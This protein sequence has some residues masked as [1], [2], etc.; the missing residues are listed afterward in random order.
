MPIFRS[1]YD[2]TFG[3]RY[4]TE[5]TK[6][7]IVKATVSNYLAKNDD[8]YTVIEDTSDM[9]VDIPAFT[10]PLYVEKAPYDGLYV[11]ARNFVS[12][13]RQ[14]G[15]KKISSVSDYNF[16]LARAGLENIWRT[17]PTSVL[18]GASP[19]PASVYS[20]WLSE[21]ISKRL[22]V[23]PEDQHKLAI[24]SAWFYYSLFSDEVRPDESEFN[25]VCQG[26][27]KATRTPVTLVMQVLDGQDYVKDITDYCSRLEDVTGSIRLR[28]FSSILLYPMLNSTWFGYSSNDMVAVGIEHVPT[29][30][31]IVLS[32]ITERA[33][34][35]S[36]LSKMIE[37]VPAKNSIN[38]FVLQMTA[39]LRT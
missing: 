19:L 25:R 9:P 18:R 16:L 39:S 13:N 35:R 23:E 14:S 36:L 7:A 17:E 3:R 15:E 21:N 33:Y 8:G 5:A 27:A 2:T 4:S 38:D 20:S 26:I 31:A 10:H 37:R 6:A 1:A 12:R 32:A 11:D 22:G 29:F 24:F 30:L 34:T 28:G